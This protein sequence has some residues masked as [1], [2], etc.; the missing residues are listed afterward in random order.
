LPALLSQVLVAFTIEF[1]N[2]FERQMPHRTTNHES[3]ADARQSLWLVSMVMWS[4]CMQFVGEKGISVAR[5]ARTKTN[6]HGMQR[7]GYV[8]VGPRPECVIRATRKGA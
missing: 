4:N 7:W 2:E 1:D 8:V 5:L 3:E 6:L